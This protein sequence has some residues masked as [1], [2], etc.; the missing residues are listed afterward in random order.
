[1]LTKQ[2]MNIVMQLRKVCNHPELFERRSVVAPFFFEAARWSPNPP[3]VVPLPLV[4]YN[5]TSAIAFNLPQ[6]VYR[7]GRFA[8]EPFWSNCCGVSFRLLFCSAE[9][10]LIASGTA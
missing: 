5:A 1:M 3:R 8:S 2:L 10:G 6:L 7:Q 4:N 9:G